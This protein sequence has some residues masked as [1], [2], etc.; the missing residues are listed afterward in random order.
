[1]MRRTTRNNDFINTKQHR[2]GNT[3]VSALFIHMFKRRRPP[4]DNTHIRNGHHQGRG[5]AGARLGSAS[6]SADDN[7]N[8]NGIPLHWHKYS[9]CLQRSCRL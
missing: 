5:A 9:N 4:S 6:T 7:A 8:G 2:A 1:M 3:A